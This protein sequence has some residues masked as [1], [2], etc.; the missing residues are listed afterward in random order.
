VAAAEAQFLAASNAARLAS[1]RA[2]N[3]VDRAWNDP[4]RWQTMAVLNTARCGF[5]SS[6]RSIREYAERIWSVPSV[7]VPSCSLVGPGAP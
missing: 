2:Q 7:P 1:A 4:S 5:F 6:D 3:D